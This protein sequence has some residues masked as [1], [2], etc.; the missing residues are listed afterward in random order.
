MKRR[1]SAI[2]YLLG[3]SLRGMAQSPLVQGLAVATIAVC[4]LMLSTLTLIVENARRVTQSW[5]IDVPITVYL[6]EEADPGT[7]DV[8][9]GRVAQLPEVVG[10]QRVTPQMAMLRLEEG[11]GG[12]EGVLEGID[13][14][15][16]PDSVEITLH[17]GTDP[18]FGPALAARLEQ[19]DGVEEVAAVG[20]WAERAKEFLRTLRNIALGVGLLVSLACLAIVWNT[21]RLGVF[22]RRAEVQ[23][24]RLV[25]GTQGFVRGPFLIEGMIQGLLGTCL[26]L[27][28]L[29]L[30]FD[31]LQP[32]LH[33]GLGLL[34]A[35]GSL[36]FFSTGQILA[37]IAFGCG[38]GLAGARAAVA[39][40]VED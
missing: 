8:I 12:Q 26:A 10:V 33:H 11:L 29:Y 9:E 38:L 19:V 7:A 30:S 22:A 13:P 6:D 27:G 32:H 14:E 1:L 16:L 31:L 21:I 20:E 25:G 34:L 17:T 35:A 23:I 5:G 36:D 18:A 39:R 28:I 2:A 4:M 37:I 3:R 15:A 24:L 40:Y